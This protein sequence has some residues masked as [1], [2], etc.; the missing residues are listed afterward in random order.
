MKPP[1]VLFVN[2]I[3]NDISQGILSHASLVC[4]NLKSPLGY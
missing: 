2:N 1:E 3:S 4:T